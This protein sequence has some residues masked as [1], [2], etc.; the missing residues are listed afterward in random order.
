MGRTFLVS[1]ALAVVVAAVAAGAMS[2]AT[3]PAI[4][5]HSLAGVELGMTKAQV[6]ARLGGHPTTRQGTYDNPGQPDGW[7]ALVF[8]KKKVAVYYKNA[9]KAVM[10]T[11]WNR[12]YKTAAGVGPCTPIAQLKMRYRSTIKANPHSTDPSR[13]VYSYTV[14][15]NLQF[16]ADGAPPYPSKR[17]TAVGLF[18]A[19]RGSTLG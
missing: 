17:V 1:L 19:H 7:T 15:K 14:G 16:A 18:D 5:Q 10:V 4:S 9:D 2:A 12:S 3:P 13:N 8:E 11:T 6:T